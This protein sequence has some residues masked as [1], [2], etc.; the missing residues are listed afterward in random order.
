MIICIENELI[1]PKKQFLELFRDIRYTIVK[2]LK[3][4]C[5]NYTGL[6]FYLFENGNGKHRL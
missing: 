6:L 4:M 2:K 5:G 1:V 3:A